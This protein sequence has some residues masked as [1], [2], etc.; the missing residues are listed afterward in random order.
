MRCDR[1]R[2]LS[3]PLIS[4]QRTVHFYSFL[5]ARSPRRVDNFKTLSGC[6]ISTQRTVHFYNFLLS[7]S[8]RRVDIFKS[9]MDASY[10]RKTLCISIAVRW[11]QVQ[12]ETIRSRISVDAF[13]KLKTLCIS[14]AIRMT[15]L[16]TWGGCSPSP[17]VKQCAVLSRH[18]HIAN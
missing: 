5:L 17:H 13:L 15:Y 2:T 6:I 8:P 18:N 14:I 11:Y 4:T 3:G 16:C 1:S 9:L 10:S 12:G 7:Q